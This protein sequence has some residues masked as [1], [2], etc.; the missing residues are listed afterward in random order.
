MA[1]DNWLCPPS[2]GC[3]E[4]D[5]ARKRHGEYLAKQ[6]K[7]K[8]DRIVKKVIKAKKAKSKLRF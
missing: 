5:W 8:A 3:W 4:C 1:D 7:Q 2:A 6:A